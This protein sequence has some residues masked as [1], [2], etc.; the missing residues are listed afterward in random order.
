MKV[1]TALANRLGNRERNEDRC[2]ILERSGTWLLLLAD[3]MGGHAGGNLASQ[4]M[5][6]SITRQFRHIPLPVKDPRR[7]LRSLLEDS[8]RDI[9]ALGKRQ[10][11]PITPRTTSVLCLVQ[12]GSA[13]WAHVGDSRLYLVRDGKIAV[14]T[15][16]HTFIEEMR[17]HGA[18]DEEQIRVHP[19]R[20]HLTH[21]LG[22]PEEIPPVELSEETV[23]TESDVIVICS[24]GLWGALDMDKVIPLFDSRSLADSV[25]TLAALAERSSTPRSDNI[26]LVT[27]RLDTSDVEQPDQQDEPAQT[28]DRNNVH[29]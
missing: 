11:P 8:H 28:D 22:S 18:L 1:E 26:S 13:W 9:V 6:D 27:L 4:Q 20:N 19:L 14:R 16:D 15:K 21:C 5:I 17:A 3:G 29:A 12:N 10:D 7:F 23:L 24:D 2:S 25:T